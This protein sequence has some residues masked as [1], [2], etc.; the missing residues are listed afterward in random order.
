[1]S[2]ARHPRHAARLSPDG[3]IAGTAAASAPGRLRIRG[4]VVCWIAIS[5]TLLT[6]ALCAAASD[7]PLKLPSPKTWNERPSIAAAPDGALWIA[8]TAFADGADDI[9]VARAASGSAEV[10]TELGAKGAADFSPCICVSGDGSVD[11]IWI[12]ERA[13]GMRVLHSRLAGGKWSP[14]RVVSG[15]LDKCLSPAVCTSGG[16]LFVAWEAIAGG[17]TDVY[18]STFD[19]SW[20]R[21][22][23][24]TTDKEADC[25]PAL[26]SQEAGNVWLAWDRCES[27]GYRVHLAE[28]SRS[29]LSGVQ[30]VDFGQ[31]HFRHPELAVAADRVWVAC[32]GFWPNP[33][34]RVFPRLCL[35]AW[36]AYLP[37]SSLVRSWDGS[38]WSTPPADP[39]RVVGLHLLPLVDARN[40]LWVFYEVNGEKKFRLRAK[41]LSAGEWR[42]A[43][44]ASGTLLSWEHRP[45][46]CTA[47][48]SVW[49]A[50]P[51]NTR[52]SSRLYSFTITGGDSYI[53]LTSLEAPAN[54]APTV[55]A[56]E[57][58]AAPLQRATEPPVKSAMVAGQKLNV[59]F[60]DLHKHSDISGCGILDGTTV[61]NYRF[62]RDWRRLDFMMN[63]DHSEHH[64]DY[65]WVKVRRAARLFS[66]DGY[67]AAYSGYEWT[68][69][70]ESRGNLRC[71]HYNPTFLTD[72]PNLPCLSASKAGSNDPNELWALTERS[73][74]PGDDFFTICHHTGRDNA[75]LQWEYYNPKYATHIEVVQSRGSYEYWNCP[76]PQRRYGDT[77]R[78]RG[79]FVQD[80]L[81]RGYTYGFSGGG[82]HSGWALTGVL[83]PAK[84]KQDI[85][86]ALKEK[87][88]YA[89]N[90][91]KIF[92]D[93]RVDGRP[94]GSDFKSVAGSQEIT[95][96]AAA[97]SRILRADLWRDGKIIQSARPLANEWR[98]TWRDDSSRL[99]RTYYYV[100]VMTDAGGIAWASPVWVTHTRTSPGVRVYVDSK[101]AEIAAPQLPFALPVVL[102]NDGSSDAAVTLVC[103]APAGW[104][105]QILP[106]PR[107]TIRGGGWS[108][109]HAVLEPSGPPQGSAKLETV[110]FGLEPGGA[111]PDAP[112]ILALHLPSGPEDAA[113]ARRLCLEL[114][115][116]PPS[117]REALLQGQEWLAQSC[118]LFRK[119]GLVSWRLSNPVAAEDVS[120]VE[121]AIA[122]AGARAELLPDLGWRPGLG[123]LYLDDDQKLGFSAA[124]IDPR[125]GA[126]E[127]V[128]YSYCAAY[129]RSP[130]ERDASLKTAG[131]GTYKVWLNGEVV[132]GLG[133]LR[134][135][136]YGGDAKPVRLLAGWNQV[137]LKI[138]RNRKYARFWAKVSAPDGQPYGDL[139]FAA[140]PE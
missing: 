90:G 48:S 109:L 40:D 115:E 38:T 86:R 57:T 1:M 10:V 19:R 76:D 14:E 88:C 113:A 30:V 12:G 58:P 85:F 17:N 126:E 97:P 7:S 39:E 84:T 64:D 75:P 98:V 93:F 117:G 92:L 45:A 2:S 46:V 81:A 56:E 27:S 95:V 29:G 62:W 79:Y 37:V 44:D 18:S 59:Y 8:W 106:S 4:R 20:S 70:F 82:D 129:I 21:P 47:G 36:Y 132:D 91:E 123:E 49:A 60:G 67:F 87:R 5:L 134:K 83:A 65:D 9:I 120:T 111:S 103:D 131:D 52:T 130:S 51:S 107:T 121:A 50:F 99:R 127:R 33:T 135:A 80:G 42:A 11:V 114:A 61:D 35:D 23:R 119:T 137:V 55:Q 6:A 68:S 13:G 54:P 110:R 136:K 43:F 100:R 16:R 69:E 25:N 138:E 122:A 96:H 74:Q 128:G 22:A 105:V 24:L 102:R 133:I 63:S 108:E 104:K 72:G 32:E 125:P 26:A 112:E 118:G 116:T 124:L 31:G 78:A 41:V 3:Q 94:M 140:S 53:H 73:L 66:D 71:G 101:Q 139:T 15:N 89:T 34:T 77:T 28:L